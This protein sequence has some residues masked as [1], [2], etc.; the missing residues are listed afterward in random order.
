MGVTDTAESSH[1]PAHTHLKV[2]SQ[3]SVL[4]ESVAY[5]FEGVMPLICWLS[6][7]SGLEFRVTLCQEAIDEYVA[8]AG[9]P[10]LTRE[11]RFTRNELHG[12]KSALERVTYAQ[13]A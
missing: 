12:K 1:P 7:F 9:F 4:G 10:E 8:Q 2:Q 6:L 13:R 3:Y 5:V 11:H